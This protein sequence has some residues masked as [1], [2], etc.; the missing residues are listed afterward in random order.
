MRS[1][2]LTMNNEQLTK[3]RPG[4]LALLS[5]ICYL[6]SVLFSACDDFAATQDAVGIGYGIIRID[7]EGAQEARTVFP[8][9]TFDK[10]VY[11]FTKAGE[12]SGV[13]HQ[14]A[15]SNV[16]TLEV[17]TYTVEVK[18][19]VTDGTDKLS[20]SGTSASFTVSSGAN[21]PVSVGLSAAAGTG[22]FNYTINYPANA[23]IKQVSLLKWSNQ[24][25]VTL[26]SQNITNGI[27]GTPDLDSGSYFLTVLIE[28][29]GHYAGIN[30]AISIYPE[31]TTTYTKSFAEADLLA[32]TINILG[33]AGVTAPAVGAAPV[34]S[35]TA[36]DQYSGTVTWNNGNPVAFA[37]STAYTATIT[38][39][40]KTGYTLAGV[41]ANTF[42]VAGASPVTHSANSGTITAVFPAT[43]AAVIN[44][45]AIQGVTPPVTGAA[46]V[47]SITSTQY[48]GTISWSPAV[49]G[50]F[51]AS[52]AYTATI[53]LTANTGY[54]LHGVAA[55]FF[56]VAGTSTAATNSANSGSVTAH[57][58]ATGVPALITINIAAI[59]GVTPPVKGA[60]PVSV[61]TATDQ[62]TGTVKWSG[63]P[64]NGVSPSTFAASSVYAATIT[65]T[66]KTG[67]TLTGVEKDFFTVAGATSPSITPSQPVSNA[68]NSGV[69]TAVFPATAS[70]AIPAAVTNN[71]IWGAYWPPESQPD[72]GVITSFELPSFKRFFNGETSVSVRH[73]EVYEH[74]GYVWAEDW[75]D[76]PPYANEFGL[77]S[78]VEGRNINGV[79]PQ[80][81]EIKGNGYYFFMIPKTYGTVS[82]KDSINLPANS[83]FDT[84]D[85][86]WGSTAM[87]L[88]LK[89]VAINPPNGSL[90]YTISFN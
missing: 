66:P 63:G 36:N 67:Y 87:T 34:S 60:T 90:L 15:G 32:T 68:E 1:E 40:P 41:N 50:T 3:V 71:L 43:A 72:V 30:E 59:P 70:E 53:T 13:D 54:T 26:N 76:E 47:T 82:I 57:F 10:Y 74:G 7:I 37:G 29:G 69:V 78:A 39:S 31:K 75:K 16:F 42:T 12:T 45:P 79:A 38:L 55:N 86:T 22:K 24:S 51:A 89:T 64:S 62:Y 2:K 11:T 88:Y 65:I 58:P 84:Y 14:P 77:L 18:A 52:T 5:V 21:S 6:L 17:G 61:I 25:A 46:P 81:I 35:I 73:T 85:V 9:L 19:Y 33:I 56:T 49:S 28:R 4:S 23:S 8:S 27:T 83:A 20:A 44:I 80:T 48:N